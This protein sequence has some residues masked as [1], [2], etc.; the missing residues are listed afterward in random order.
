MLTPVLYINM[1]F[2]HL[3]WVTVDL[4]SHQD[5]SHQEGMDGWNG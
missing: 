1:L 3:V 4:D 5:T 2:T